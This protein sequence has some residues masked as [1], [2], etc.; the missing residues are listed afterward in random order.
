MGLLKKKIFYGWWIVLS[1]SIICGL[2]Y[3]TWMY[4]FGVFFKPMMA[5]FGWTRAMTAGAYSLRSIQGGIASPILGWVIDKYP[6][7]LEAIV[8]AGHE[9]AHHGYTHQ[10]PAT[11]LAYRRRR[12]RTED[13]CGG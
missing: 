1:T 11:F 13:L 10:P 4:S 2:G 8:K 7:A 9:V 5:E 12:R 3:G 6:A